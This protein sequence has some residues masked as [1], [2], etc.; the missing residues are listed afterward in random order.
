V[1]KI[2]IP[3]QDHQLKVP[4]VRRFEYVIFLEQANP[5][6]TFIH[7]NVYVKWTRHV[8]ERLKA[9]F[10]KLTALHGGP[11]YALHTP[12]DTKHEKFLKMFGFEW[13][14]SYTN[15]HGEHLEIYTT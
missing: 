1:N 2:R 3:P 15:R 9:D 6:T 7:C 8:K 10:D 11:F 13:K 12:G 5:S 4:V 14:A